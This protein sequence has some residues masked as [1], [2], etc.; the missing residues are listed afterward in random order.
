L[1]SQR[2]LKNI[3]LKGIDRSPFADIEVKQPSLRYRSEID[4][5]KL[6]KAASTELAPKVPTPSPA[7]IRTPPR[8]A[9]RKS[10]AKSRRG[11]AYEYEQEVRFVLAADPV[12]LENNGGIVR[13]VSSSLLIDEIFISP[14]IPLTEA[15]AIRD[16][17]VEICPFL[18]LKKVKISSLLDRERPEMRRICIGSPLGLSF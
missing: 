10:K 11:R 18:S 8:G 17:I 15:I 9:N 12:H 16:L 2:V 4:F 1:F 14:Y 5:E 13:K 6:L 7:T 3:E